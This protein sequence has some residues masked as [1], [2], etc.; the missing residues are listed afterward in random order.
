[1]EGSRSQEVG[2]RVLSPWRVACLFRQL[3]DTHPVFLASRNSMIFSSSPV[4]T[5]VNW[6]DNE[7]GEKMDMVMMA[8]TLRDSWRLWL[9]AHAPC[10]PLGGDDHIVAMHRG[11]EMPGQEDAHVG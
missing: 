10:R 11:D 2:M 6:N 7:D 4:G 1:M 3:K 8:N 5:T 9:W